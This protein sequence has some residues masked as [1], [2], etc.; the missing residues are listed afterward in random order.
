[1]GWGRGGVREFELREGEREGQ[2]AVGP[3][4]V[5]AQACAAL[6][7]GVRRNREGGSCDTANGAKVR[8]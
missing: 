6:H 8:L 3:G 5:A 7:V 1:M 2:V 4:G